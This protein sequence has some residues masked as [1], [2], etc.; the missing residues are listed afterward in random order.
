MVWA[1]ACA[2]A[3][4]V[5]PAPEPAGIALTPSACSEATADTDSDGLTDAC[6]HALATAFAPVLMMHHTR[7][8]APPSG[9]SRGIPGGYFHAA[10]RTEEGV[11][12]VYMPAYYRDCGWR[13]GWCVLLNC[14]GHAGDS[15]LIA[16]DVRRLAS[17]SWATE[18]VFLS[19]HCFGRSARDCRWYDGTALRDFDWLDGVERGAPVVWVSDGRNA[20][21]PSRAA[22][23]RGHGGM[24]ACG[25][26]PEVYRF[27]VM[28]ARNIGS[29]AVPIRQPGQVPG[30]VTGAVVEP[31]DR[32]IV[33]HQAV[34][35]F[36]T[37]SAPFGGWQGGGA[38][39]T[40]YARYLDH[41]GL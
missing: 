41:I 10:Q 36:W 17:G 24:D 22:C 20:N 18:S 4:P 8:T 6:E 15:E 28:R 14:R 26:D 19:A 30:C 37:G 7:C 1:L 35:C 39:A 27:P 12:L 2:P 13:S 9:A 32:L 25:S 23:E 33:S 3:R 16:V 31:V 11:R 21:Y 29:R 34:E 38:G 5:D 40:S